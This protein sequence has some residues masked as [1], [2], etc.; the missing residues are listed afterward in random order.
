[1]VEFVPYDSSLHKDDFLMLNIEYL[2]WD[3]E[4]MLEKHDVDIASLLGVTAERYAKGLLNHYG[5]LGP[6]DGIVY[7][8]RIEGRIEGMGALHRLES[9]VAEIKRMYI[10]KS[11]RGKGLG[12]KM[13]R[14]LVE[15]AREFGYSAIRLD[16]GDFMEAAHQIYRSEG[17]KEIEQYPGVQTPEP[18]LPYTLFMEKEL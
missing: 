11:H 18:F 3:A 17:F 13:L 16:T 8:I 9:D 4:M 6:P 2:S 1:M 14:K 12:K 7:L 5:S 15:K 10:R